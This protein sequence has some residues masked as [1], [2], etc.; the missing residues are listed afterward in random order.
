MRSSP[1]ISNPGLHWTFHTFVG[2]LSSLTWL[3]F[4]LA[5]WRGTHSSIEKIWRLVRITSFHYFKMKNTTN[6]S[7]L[8]IY[9]TIS[10]YYYLLSF[11]LFAYIWK[12]HIARYNVK[13]HYHNISKYLRRVVYQINTKATASSHVNEWWCFISPYNIWILLKIPK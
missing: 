5:T 6:C 11:H 8:I 1:N 9:Y 7:V 2:W 3:T 13:K 12:K 4:P 10:I